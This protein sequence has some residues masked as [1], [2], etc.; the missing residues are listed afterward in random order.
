MSLFH[1]SAGARWR[2]LS[3]MCRPRSIASWS[4]CPWRS[5][6]L[7][8]LPCQTHTKDPRRQFLALLDT[9]PKGLGERPKTYLLGK[10]PGDDADE[11]LHDVQTDLAPFLADP[12][13]LPVN[14]A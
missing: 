9:W 10:L 12:V 13:E 6:I 7:S 2:S 5:R 11:R 4:A 14:L 1:S 8:M 3:D